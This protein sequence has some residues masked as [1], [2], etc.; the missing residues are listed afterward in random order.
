MSTEGRDRRTAI[1]TGPSAPRIPFPTEITDEEIARHFSLSEPER[2]LISDRRRPD[3]R[4]GFCLQLCHVKWRGRFATSF[5]SVPPRLVQHV[6][7]QLGIQ[8]SVFFKYPDNENTALRH[9]AAIQRHLGLR[10]WNDS[11]EERLRRELLSLALDGLRELR[12]VQAAERWLQERKVILPGVS[13]L[14]EV[15]RAALDSVEDEVVERIDR[16]LDSDMRTKM[17]DLIEIP[18]GRRL[19]RLQELKGHPRRASSTTLLSLCD[20]IQVL[21][22]MGVQGID[23]SSV[24]PDWASDLADRVRH[25][26]VTHLGRFRAAKRRALLA[27]FLVE[28]FADSI[29]ATI[30]A[31]SRVMLQM[32]G[33]VRAKLYQESGEFREAACAELLAWVKVGGLLRQSENAERTVSEAVLSK[34]PREEIER[35][36]ERA[37]ELARSQQAT[38]IQ[39]L[40]LKYSFTR[41]FTPRFLDALEFT[42]GPGGEE[43]V[44]GLEVLRQMNAEG[45]KKLPP[46]TPVTFVPAAWRPLV[47]QEDGGIHRGAYEVCLFTALREA[48]EG[49]EVFVSGSRRYVSIASLLYSDDAWQTQR[50]QAYARLG[51]PQDPDVFLQGIEEQLTKAAQATDAGLPTNTFARIENGKLRFSKEPAV[52]EDS[53]V[54]KLRDMIEARV[55]TTQIEHILREVD[56]ETGFTE[57]FQPP[58]GYERRLPP[59]PLRRAL[60]AGVLAFGTNLGLWTMGQMAR[61]ISYSQ[62]AHVAEWNLKEILVSAANDH[63]VNSHHALPLSSVWGEGGKSSSDGIR[64]RLGVSSLLGE[65]N[66]KYFGWGDGLTSYKAM[67]DQWSIFSTQLISCHESEA[68]RMLSA[69]LSN[70]TTLPLHGGHAADTAGASEPIFALCHLAGFPFWPRLADLDEVRLWRLERGTKLRHIEPLFEGCVDRDAIRAEYDNIVRLVASLV[71]RLAPAHI[72]GRCLAASSRRNPLARAVTAL[73]RLYRTIYVLQYL[74][75]P[76]LRRTVH[77]LLCRHESQNELGRALVIGAKGEF[78]TGDYEGAAARAA[79]NTLLENIVLY[80]NTRRMTDI[81]RQLR[82]EGHDVKDALLANV[83]PLFHRHINFRGQYEFGTAPENERTQ[84]HA[85]R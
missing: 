8:L 14:R 71:D 57:V 47:V 59:E 10:R 27:C 81:V 40:V 74:D 1:E 3:N 46:E 70:R 17:E 78:R 82:E 58:L 85:G 5:E 20:R 38:L 21:R 51:L 77:R 75:S 56:E 39:K 11:D 53:E 4:I 35:S 28:T 26:A 13:V 31:F 42:P 36:V 54:E 83:S 63:L 2:G 69:L 34:V 43:I 84:D 48:I 61:G 62:L 6:A 9:N 45:K 52:E 72:L 16:R 24:R 23:L 79:C 80:W 15:V 7:A 41:T 60:L 55:P 44:R 19:S 33:R 64:F 30:R 18:R 29:D 50:M 65:P 32:E 66:P 76:V 22:R 67:C 37:Q 73:G 12:M 25:Y 49:G 68:L